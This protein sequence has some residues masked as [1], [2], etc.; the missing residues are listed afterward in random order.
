MNK[1][2][3]WMAAASVMG[4]LWMS[5][6]A[7]SSVTEELP[8]QRSYL[9]SARSAAG[10]LASFSAAFLKSLV[11]EIEGTNEKGEAVT[12]QPMIPINGLLQLG[13]QF[14]CYVG[15][16]TP[17]DMAKGVGQAVKNHPLDAAS[18]VVA[19]LLMQ[20]GPENS[21]V[22]DVVVSVVN[23]LKDAKLVVPVLGAVVFTNHK[24]EVS[25]NMKTVVAVATLSCVMAVA[26]ADAGV[27]AGQPLASL[28][29]YQERYSQTGCPSEVSNLFGYVDSC[30]KAGGGMLRCRDKIDALGLAASNGNVTLVEFARHEAPASVGEVVSRVQY[31]LNGTGACYLTAVNPQDPTSL[32]REVCLADVTKPQHTFKVLPKVTMGQFLKGLE[33]GQQAP[34]VEIRTTRDACAIHCIRVPLTINPSDN[35]VCVL[36]GTKGLVDLEQL[37]FN[38]KHPD[39]HSVKAA[40]VEIKNFLNSNYGAGQLEGNQSWLIEVPAQGSTSI[41]PIEGIKTALIRKWSL[42]PVKAVSTGESA[43]PLRTFAAFEKHYSGG[44]CPAE[45]AELFWDVTKCLESRQGMGVCRLRLDAAG[46]AAVNGTATLVEFARHGFHADVVSRVE[47]GSNGTGVCFLTS[48]STNIVR[49]VCYAGQAQ[50]YSFRILPNVTM[51]ELRE[52]L[53]PFRRAPV[54]EIKLGGQA[55]ASHRITLPLKDDRSGMTE[56]VYTSTNGTANLQELCFDPKQPEQHQVKPAS[57]EIKSHLEQLYGDTL[58]EGPQSWKI[59]TLPLKR[60]VIHLSETVRDAVWS[61]WYQVPLQPVPVFQPQEYEVAKIER[62][63]L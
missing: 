36:S 48:D 60:T 51:A 57:A 13:E 33:P 12:F 32:V 39:Q 10:N 62:D 34:V 18:L 29:A 45:V 43:Q 35:Q 40:P 52:G 11:C 6:Q 1:L 56:C 59:K 47:Y 44:D 7:L 2:K 30:L 14:E 50:P 53:Y 9:S 46:L 41:D 22:R 49:E 55:C 61:W 31:S 37:C 54:V 27:F 23:R 19:P 58:R 3:L 25:Q 8:E 26:A 5:P 4:S 63:E 17:L 28:A 16:K 20:F 24:G 15:S 38:P 21:V 42:T